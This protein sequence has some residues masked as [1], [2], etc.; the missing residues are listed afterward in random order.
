MTDVQSKLPDT[1]PLDETRHTVVKPEQRIDMQGDLSDEERVARAVRAFVRDS[2]VDTAVWLESCIHC[3][4][5]AEACHFYVQTKDP[6]YVPIRKLELM[7]RTHRREIGPFR[8]LYRLVDK[9]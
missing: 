3:G 7:R 5:C 4:Q 6:K 8:W 1:F 9:G 2:W